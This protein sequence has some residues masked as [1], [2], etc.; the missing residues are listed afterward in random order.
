VKLHIANLLALKT[1]G[2]GKINITMPQ[3]CTICR[4]P[5]RLEIEQAMLAGTSLRTV[6]DRCGPSKTAL[7]RH[8]PHISQ[9]LA[10]NKQAQETA[11]T[12]ALLDDVR[13]GEGRAERL[14]EKAE[15]ILTAALQDKDRRT[16]LQAIRVAVDVMG[17]ARG[18]LELRG[19]INGE[20]GRDR[21]TAAFSVQI[22]CPWSPDRENMPRVTF[23]DNSSEGKTEG[24]FET[25]KVGPG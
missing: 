11:R 6:A 12:G 15:E 20:L 4:H 16:A 19:E 5:Q 22:V 2:G 13:T 1:F 9:A 7:L 21:S 3:I 24:L 18:Y 23:A 14:Y 25:V 17:E 8:R 10:L